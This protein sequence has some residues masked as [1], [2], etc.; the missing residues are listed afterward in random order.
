[1]AGKSNLVAPLTRIWSAFWKEGPA[2]LAQAGRGVVA[3]IDGW[4]L[5]SK[6]AMYGIAVARMIFA[7]AALGLLLTNFNTRHYTYGS[8]AAWSG[9]LEEANGSF[10]G[11]PLFEVFFSIAR[12]DAAVTVYFLMLI[13]LAAALLVGYRA[14]LILPAF[15][16]LWIGLIET[17]Y[18]GG[19]QGDNALRIALF[20]MLFTDHSARWSFDARRRGRSANSTGTIPA[21][22]WRGTRILPAGLTNLW[23]NLALVALAC[24]VFMIYVSGALFKAGGEPWQN[25]TAIYGPLH[26]MR[27]GPWPELS[28]L[29]TTFGW[30]VAL[31]SI[32]SVMLQVCFPGALLFRW[33]R[34]PVLF[35]MISFHAGIALLMGLP[36]FSLAMVGI[37]AIF[38]RDI[39]WERMANWFKRSARANEEAPPAPAPVPDELVDTGERETERVSVGV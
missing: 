30:V 36:W 25:G 27:F 20:L 7:A 5:D 9:Q 8:G 13:V 32:G 2:H 14:R 4:L 12:N 21:K 19:D 39:T 33:T 18:F 26:T 35:A 24:Q 29:I 22:L 38:I 31:G 1:M 34:I 17:P 11:N 10:A 3:T 28:E 15:L 16:V 23:H 6:H 37:D